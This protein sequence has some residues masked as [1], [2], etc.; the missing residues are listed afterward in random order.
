MLNSVERLNPELN[1]W[2]K[3]PP[4]LAA[5]VAVAAAAVDGRS[6]GNATKN[7]A[8]CIIMLKTLLKIMFFDTYKKHIKNHIKNR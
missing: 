7:K 3:M 8:F 1:E 6:A 4:M 5:R 2:E